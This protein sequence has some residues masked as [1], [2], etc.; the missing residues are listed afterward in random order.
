MLNGEPPISTLSVPCVL[1]VCLSHEAEDLGMG[2]EASVFYFDGSLPASGACLPSKGKLKE[3][4][5]KSV[6][7]GSVLPPAHGESLS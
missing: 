5:L 1:T 3:P 7:W 4:R 6:G 2:R